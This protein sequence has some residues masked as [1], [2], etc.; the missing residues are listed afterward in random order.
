[1]AHLAFAAQT[2]VKK[3]QSKVESVETWGSRLLVGYSDGS[4]HVFQQKQQRKTLTL[5]WATT[6][7]RGEEVPS[8]QLERSLS[9]WCDEK[10]K[11][12]IKILVVERWGLFSAFA[13][14]TFTLMILAPCPARSPV[15]RGQ[16]LLCERTRLP[17]LYIDPEVPDCVQMGW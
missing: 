6:Y 12:I 8:F 7:P 10:K 16:R 1:M 17:N 15:E 13:I 3:C 2:L 4:M 11:P 9:R 14:L 5:R